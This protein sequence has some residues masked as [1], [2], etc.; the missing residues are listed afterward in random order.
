ML[1]MPCAQFLSYFRF[2]DSVLNVAVGSSVD[3]L[4]PEVPEISNLV[5]VALKYD[6]FSK[7]YSITDIHV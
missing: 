2:V 1:H 7:H 5:D 3:C 6:E 4:C